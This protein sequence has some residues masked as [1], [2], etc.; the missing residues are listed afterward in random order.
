MEHIVLYRFL[1]DADAA[2]ADTGSRALLWLALVR[3]TF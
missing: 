1:A 3:Q 2:L